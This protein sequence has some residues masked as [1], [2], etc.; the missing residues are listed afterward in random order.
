MRDWIAKRWNDPA[1][2]EILGVLIFSRLALVVVGWI[3]L[4]RLPWQFYSPTYNP[5]TNPAILMWIRWDAMWYTGI[6][7]HGYWT[8]ALAFFPLYPLLIAGVHWIFFLP[9]DYAA[10]L[11]ANI[12]LVGF[13]VTFYYLVREYYEDGLARQ[14]VLMAIMFPTAF[15]MSAAYT[16][17]IFLWLTVSAFLAAKR[18]RLGLASLLGMLAALT[19]NEG[20]F[21]VIPI[22]WAYYRKNGFRWNPRILWVLLIPLG[23][24]VF[25][26]YQW[27]DFGSP[28]AFIQSQSYWGRHVTWPWVGFFLAFNVI[29]QGSPLQPSTVLS[30]IDLSSALIMIGL[31]IFGWR[32]KL[33]VEWMVYWGIL[34][35]IDIS[36]PDVT[37]KSPLLSMSRLVL[38]LFPAFV[39]LGMLSMNPRW[40]RFLEWMLP[41]LQVTFFLIFVT[42]HW[43]A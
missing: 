27:V 11:V 43:I 24:I 32:R 29:S 6:A 23:F 33:P 35:L 10:V 7:V 21:T 3:G 41:A 8:Q 17:G 4:A 26:V 5:S 16:E 2:K 9:V 19:R 25:M 36:A 34:L 31:W 14:A 38:I 12:G 42:W 13:S 22:L 18:D 15:Y 40:K 20:A 37:G 30:M 39:T 28:V 1:V